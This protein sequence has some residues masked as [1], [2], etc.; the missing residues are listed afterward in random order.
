MISSWKPLS[1]DE[2]TG[3]GIGKFNVM[4]TLH[5]LG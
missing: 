1:H 2:I 3:F 5:M 4:L